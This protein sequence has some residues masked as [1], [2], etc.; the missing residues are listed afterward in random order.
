MSETTNWNVDS[1][2]GSLESTGRDLDLISGLNNG[3][4]DSPCAAQKCPELEET[5]NPEVH[6][7]VSEMSNFH[8]EG[9]GAHL[10]LGS[11]LHRCDDVFWKGRPSQ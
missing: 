3:S 7:S 4:G 5:A 6:T 11:E 9:T 2:I 10:L 8:G 1:E